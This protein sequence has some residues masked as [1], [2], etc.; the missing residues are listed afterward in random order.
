MYVIRN[1]YCFGPLFI[2]KLS[3]HAHQCSFYYREHW[4]IL[5][6]R[7]IEAVAQRC[8]VK[9][10]FLKNSKNAQENTYVRVSV[11]GTLAQVFF[12]GFL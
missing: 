4:N 12:C 9:K 3:F 2:L 8:S 6:I 5:R 1:L 7:A 11:P 10:L